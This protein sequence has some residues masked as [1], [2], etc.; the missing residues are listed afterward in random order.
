MKYK[1]G[2]IYDGEWDNDLKNGKGILCL[3]E[4]DYKLFKSKINFI[5]SNNIQQIFHLNLKQDVYYGSFLNDKKE[6]NGIFFQKSVKYKNNENLYIG[7]FHE[8][9]MNYEGNTYFQNEKY[10]E[11]IINSKKFFY[12]EKLHF[13]EERIFEQKHNINNK[14]LSSFSLTNYFISYSSIDDL[15]NYFNIS[16][17]FF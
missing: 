9:K 4:N 8:D 5:F 3:N 11:I 17:Y 10:S 6:G 2:I 7:K 16:A 13:K 14:C 12:D 15:P 1:S